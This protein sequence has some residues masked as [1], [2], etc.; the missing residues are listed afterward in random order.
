MGRS[1]LCFGGTSV[2]TFSKKAVG[3]AK[4]RGILPE[5][6]GGK[7]FLC[8][9]GTGGQATFVR[10]GTGG[11]GSPGAKFEK[12]AIVGVFGGHGAFLIVVGDGQVFVGRGGTR[13]KW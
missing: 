12:R 10:G 6:I 4:L 1:F 5:V 13:G 2:L 11:D 9:W 7:V 3:R 8:S